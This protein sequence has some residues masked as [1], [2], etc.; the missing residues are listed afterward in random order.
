LNFKLTEFDR[1]RV[2]DLASK[3]SDGLL[4]KADRTELNEYERV[5]S[6]IELLQSKAR[7]SLER[8]E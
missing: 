5:A 7:I 8:A 6:V 1:D 2:N 4:T 3:A